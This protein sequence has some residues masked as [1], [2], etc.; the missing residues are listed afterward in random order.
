MRLVLILLIFSVVG[1]NESWSASPSP[2]PEPKSL[3][4]QVGEQ[5]RLPAGASLQIEKSASVKLKNESRGPVLIAVKPGS[6]SFIHDGVR[7]E[8]SVFNEKRMRGWRLLK[9]W[10]DLHPGLELHAQ[11]GELVFS[12][13]LLQVADW[14]D[15]ADSCRGCEYRAELRFPTSLKAEIDRQLGE[16]AKILGLA[17]PSLR[18]NPAAEWSLP[19][20]AKNKALADLAARLGIEIIEDKESV[21]LNP[22]VKT[23]IYVMEVRRAFSQKWGIRWPESISAQVIPGQGAVGTPMEFSAHALET[24]GHGKILASPTL[25]CRS[26]EEAE[27]LAG[28][29]FPIKVMN[30]HAQGVVW[31]R[32][33]IV[34][35]VKPKADRFGRINMTLETEVSTIDASHTV[36][37]I[38]GLLT[39]R[40]LSHFDLEKSTVIALSG[41]IKSEE[42]KAVQGLPGLARIPI[43][44][45]L[46]GSQ[47]FNENRTELVIFVKPEVVDVNAARGDQ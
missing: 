38:P 45:G 29:E 18:F 15:L 42:S 27:F 39:N 16:K 6:L 28:G 9:H 14:L 43:L 21:V 26:G 30:L 35:K 12:G 1:S 31:K 24:E 20:G 44:G 41:L 2:N 37:G 25:L 23:Q 10:V 19:S 36:D 32:Y 47:D 33:G 46:F 22:M 13:E 4:L 11:R 34:L 3:I 7:K 8:I 5:L 17:A 40:V